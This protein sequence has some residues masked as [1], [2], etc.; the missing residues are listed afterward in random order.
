MSGSLKKI[1]WLIVMA[2][3]LIV[4]FAVLG[5]LFIHEKRI[6]IGI[7]LAGFVGMAVYQYLAYRSFIKDCVSTIELQKDEAVNLLFRE[8]L[9]ETDNSVEK[10][11]LYVSIGVKNP[12]VMGFLSPS[13]ILP[14]HCKKH[15]ELKTIL[16]HECFHIKRHDTQYKLIML[17]S[18][19]FLWYNPLAYIIRY[20]S[21]QDIEISCDEALLRGKTKD[22]RLAYGEFLIDNVKNM[23][24]KG[25]AFNAYWSNSSKRILKNRIDA[26]VN[27]NRKWDLFAKIA[28]V[29]LVAEACFS[30]VFLT[31]KILV[32]YKKVNA[33]INEY[34]D[35][36]VPNIYNEAAIKSML[37]VDP[38]LQHN[39]GPE[40][41]NENDESY[42]QK[43]FGQISAQPFS[44]WQIKSNRPAMFGFVA[45]ESLQRLY[46][47]LENPTAFSSEEYE[48]NPF[49]KSYEILYREKLAG[50]INN[51]VWGIIWKVYRSDLSSSNGYKEGY[52]FTIEGEENYLYYETAVQVKMI[53]PY[54]FETV[55]Y[56]DLRKTIDA[57][58]QKYGTN[59]KTTFPT[60]VS[61]NKPETLD[62]TEQK[63]L[64]DEFAEVNAYSDVRISFP[65]NL[66]EGYMLATAD[67]AAH[68][69][70]CVLYKTKDGGKHWS[71]VRMNSVGAQHAVVYDFAFFDEHEG[72]MAIHMLIG[73][74]PEL[75]RTTDSGKTWERVSFSVTMEDFCQTTIP[76]RDGDKY[77]VYVGKEGSSIGEGEKACYES[78]DGGQNWKYT[79]QVMLE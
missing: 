3:F 43:E 77:F 2:E 28:I 50:D 60:L 59:Y 46:F 51:S 48:L 42:P 4:H 18:N 39:Y 79:G 23:N 8:V 12:F 63:K 74:P 58:K 29:F 49:R 30:I 70:A 45:E 31:K 32:E 19:C 27:E 55:G 17:V 16:L 36:I 76:V 15:L 20:V 38:F 62:L 44:P 26:I 72:Y 67:K 22:E 6:I 13:V 47:Y 24:T 73:N 71:E 56:A 5:W 35:S 53:E 37:E 14:E 68:Q 54:L 40:Q 65:E 75:L 11:R 41:I 25:N 7:Y 34:E 10:V 78:T 9:S 69:V 52:A 64:A 33:P 61:Y 21:Y 1:I 66:T 57:Y